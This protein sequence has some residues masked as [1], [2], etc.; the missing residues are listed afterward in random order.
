MKARASP[1]TD[2]VATN[3]FRFKYILPTPRPYGA[4]V[5]KRMSSAN[6]DCTS[7][8]N[9]LQGYKRDAR[10]P[11]PVFVVRPSDEEWFAEFKEELD[12]L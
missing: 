11:N 9:S 6:S 5:T 1:T 10:E 3:R 2:V 12:N 8:D 7:A 4:R